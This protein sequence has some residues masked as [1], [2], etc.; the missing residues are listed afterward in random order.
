MLAREQ[1]FRAPQRVPDASVANG[2][3]MRH[4][5]RAHHLPLS[6]AGHTNLQSILVYEPRVPLENAAV[7]VI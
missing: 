6:D 7:L 5:D 1:T 3:R 2:N 4:R